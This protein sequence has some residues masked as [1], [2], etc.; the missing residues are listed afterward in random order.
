MHPYLV[1]YDLVGTDETSDDYER[2]IAAIK[3]YPD[4][5]KIQKS[6]WVVKS[7]GTAK[8]I[9]EGLSP[10]T[11]S[12]DRLLIFRLD[13]SQWWGRNVIDGIDALKIFIG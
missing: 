11:D 12:N 10:H 7:S 6:V 4:F 9:Y 2:L 3:S 13:P 1:T 8:E 5:L